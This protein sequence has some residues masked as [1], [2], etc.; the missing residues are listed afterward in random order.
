MA[1]VGDLCHLGLR[2]IEA[3]VALAY[4]AEALDHCD[5]LHAEEH[6]KL[7]DRDRRRA[8]AV[9]HHFDVLHL[10]AGQTAGVDE[11][12]AAADRRAVLV[13]VEHRDVADFLEL[14]LDLKAARRGDVLQID[15]AERARDQ[16]D[17]AHDLVHILGSH[18]K[19]ERIHV[20]ERLEQRALA[21]HDRHARDRADVAQAEHSRAVRNDRNQVVAAGIGVAQRRV[22]LDLE[23]GLSHAG[24]IGDRQ[25]VLAVD[26][27]PRDDLDL[28]APLL[29]R[30]EG[31]LF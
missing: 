19:R 29:M 12:R 27:A 13:V 9:D 7:G 8:A 22:V 10:A 28:A 2:G 25:I 15:A 4:D 11:R 3:L 24:R 21:L 5:M 14:A 23:A 26:L 1:A 6:Q 30:L 18:T 20:R 31:A 16:L 17:G